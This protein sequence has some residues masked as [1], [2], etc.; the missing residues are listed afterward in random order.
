MTEHPSNHQMNM[1]TDETARLIPATEQ[2]LDY[3]RNLLDESGLPTDDIIEK[4]DCLYLFTV[5][6]ER[7]G[8]GGLECHGS[9]AL[10][11]SIAVDPANRGNGYGSLLC[12]QLFERAVARDVTQLYLLTTTAETFFEDLGFHELQRDDAPSA[13][14]QTSEFRRLCPETATCMTKELP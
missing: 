3:V 13:I 6:S 8:V 2:Q 9:V 10:L 7:V 12:Q 14:Q 1:D 5:D 11:R 4:R